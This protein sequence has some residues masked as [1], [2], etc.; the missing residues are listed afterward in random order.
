MKPSPWHR[1]DALARHL[2]PF[3]LTLA[4]V[5]LGVL[6]LHVPGY[7]RVVPLLPLMAVYHWSVHRPELLPAY[8]VFAI[9][10]LQDSLGGAPIGVNAV[11]YLCVYGVVLSQRRFFVGKSFVIVWLGFAVVGAGAVGLS[12]LLVSAFNM[13]LVEPR[14][15]VFQYLVTLGGFPLLA[16]A[17]LGWQRAF[18][19]Q[20]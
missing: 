6:P 1:V 13:T 19:G 7:E 15:A 8:A 16:W 4:L 2:T 12:W 10:L 11:V 17:F 14:A 9:G 5:I 3:G 20:E 18:L